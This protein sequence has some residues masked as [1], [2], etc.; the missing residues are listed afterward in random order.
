MG[1]LNCGICATDGLG[2]EE[3]KIA[4]KMAA[5]LWTC[6]PALVHHLK[7]NRHRMYQ[8]AKQL[9]CTENHSE[10]L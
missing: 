10:A 5:D 3:N 7:W 1:T 9:S 6:L 2:R 8:Y 4:H